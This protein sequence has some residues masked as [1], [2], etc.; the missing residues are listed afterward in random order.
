MPSSLLLFPLKSAFPGNTIHFL[1]SYTSGVLT[2]TSMVEPCKGQRSGHV[3]PSSPTTS[4][5][6][7]AAAGSSDGPLHGHWLQVPADE[8]PTCADVT[9]PNPGDSHAEAVPGN[10]F[11]FTIRAVNSS[12]QAAVTECHRRGSSHNH[13]IYSSQFWSLG[14]PSS[15]CQQT[16]SL[17]GALSWPV[18]G[19]HRF[20]RS[21]GREHTLVHLPL[22]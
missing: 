7:T 13:H 9:C 11:G 6:W 8:P 10:P 5:K 12:A 21:G 20:V 17:L 2:Y 14:H 22:L 19:C 15:K 18:D 4:V 16:E 3:G 1:R